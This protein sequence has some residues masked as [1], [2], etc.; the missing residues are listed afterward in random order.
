MVDFTLFFDDWR[1]V[2]G[3]KFP[4]KMRRAVGG[5]DHRGVDGHQGEG[6]PEDRSEEVRGRRPEQVPS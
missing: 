2:D 3:V 5:R 6:Q 1:D 4:H